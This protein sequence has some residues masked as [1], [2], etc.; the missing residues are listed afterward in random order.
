MKLIIITP[1][2]T[3]PQEQEAL[4]LLM[5][6]GA[7]TIHLRK[8]DWSFQMTSHFIQTINPEYHSRIVIH[9][10]YKIADI[11]DIKGVHLNKR[12][13]NIEILDRQNINSNSLHSIQELE[14]ADLNCKYHFLSPIYESISKEGHSP[15]ITREELLEAQQSGL[16]NKSTIALGGITDENIEELHN[17]G[18]GGVAILGSLW[19]EWCKDFNNE[20]LV[21]RYLQMQQ[22]CNKLKQKSIPK[23]HYITKPDK[24]KPN[25]LLG[26]CSQ[27]PSMGVPLV[28]LRNKYASVETKINTAK[29]LRRVCKANNSTLIINDDPHIALKTS[30]DG[31]HLGK[32]DMPIKQARE[33]LGNNFII[34]GTANSFEDI[35]K[36]VT[37]GVDY[38]GLGPFRFTTTKDNLSPILGLD[39]YREII[40]KCYKHN[41]DTPIIA[42]GGITQ[43]DIPHL[44]DSG[45][46]G[47]AISSSLTLKSDLESE[48]NEKINIIKT[49]NQKLQ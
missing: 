21:A 15:S 8:P 34:G 10:H 16:I 28:Q 35:V 36:L 22:I 19:C 14:Q 29:E 12:N 48:I 27:Y 42:I 9:D 3:Y 20:K 47:I 49:I 4:T 37:D 5:K 44:I 7:S 6:A 13:S 25:E 43:E 33:L 32:N 2:G 39:G 23:L 24:M 26:S 41:I 30:A 31:V 38:I 18:F 17:L 11:Y 46:H 1:P 45:V 40:N